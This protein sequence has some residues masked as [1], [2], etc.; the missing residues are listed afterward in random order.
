LFDNLAMNQMLAS[1]IEEVVGKGQLGGCTGLGCESALR[2]AAGTLSSATSDEITAATV[3]GIV[4]H[5]DASAIEALAAEIA[6]E[7]GLECRV[8]MYVGSFSVRFQPCGGDTRSR[9]TCAKGS[10]TPPLRRTEPCSM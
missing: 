10:L 6:T 3:V 9:T 7:F 2:V 1:Q 5:D 4:G 8:R